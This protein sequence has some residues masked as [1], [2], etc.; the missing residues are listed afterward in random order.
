MTTK[1]A[2]LIDGTLAPADARQALALLRA[3][4]D[5]GGDGLLEIT[6]VPP[7]PALPTQPALQLLVAAANRLDGR[8]SEMPRLGDEARRLVA[9]AARP[10]PLSPYRSAS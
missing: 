2:F 5:R 8:V 7:A 10:E 9:L 3:W 1:N 4:L 6:S